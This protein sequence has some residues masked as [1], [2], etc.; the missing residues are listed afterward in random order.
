MGRWTHLLGTYPEKKKALDKL[1][2]SAKKLTMSQLENMVSHR[3]KLLQD[4][5]GQAAATKEEYTAAIGNITRAVG[6]R[7]DAKCEA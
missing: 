2:E 1:K 6:G 5:K 7:R 4:L 3:Y